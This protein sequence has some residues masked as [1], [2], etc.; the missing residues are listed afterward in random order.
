MV[1]LCAGVALSPQLIRSVVMLQRGLIRIF[2]SKVVKNSKKNFLGAHTDMYC[3]EYT[4][5]E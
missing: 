3:D 4:G 2:F 5:I 1:M